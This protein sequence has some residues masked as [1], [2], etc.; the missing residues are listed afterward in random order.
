MPS[1]WPARDSSKSLSHAQ[2]GSQ[3]GGGGGW[4]RLTAGGV[5]RSDL[6][7]LASCSM[8][9]HLEIWSSSVTDISVVDSMPL[10]E[11]FYCIKYSQ[12]PSIKDLLPLASCPRLRCL[13]LCG[14]SPV[15]GCTSLEHL[16]INGCPLITNLAPLSTLMNTLLCN[17]IDPETSLLPLILCT[18]LEWL[19]CDENALDHEELE[20]RRPKIVYNYC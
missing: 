1:G 5:M 6:S 3:T 16:D 12:Q 11:E 7:P 13:Y 20:K 10:L 17:G 4:T 8:M 2:P 9:E 15:S 14:N 19:E 18:G